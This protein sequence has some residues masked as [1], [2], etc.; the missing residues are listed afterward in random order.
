MYRLLASELQRHDAVKPNV[1]TELTSP[2]SWNENA[3]PDPEERIQELEVQL[4]EL[5][6]KN[7]AEAEKVT[8][9]IDRTRQLRQETEQAQQRAT[10]LQ[11]QAATK[12]RELEEAHRQQRQKQELLDRIAQL[13]SRVCLRRQAL[14]RL[15]D[16]QRQLKELHERLKAEDEA[17]LA[18]IVEEERLRVTASTDS[19]EG[20][21]GNNVGS[22]GDQ[23]MDV[24]SAVEDQGDSTQAVISPDKAIYLG[25]GVA[26]ENSAPIV[27]ISDSVG[28][29][30]EPSI[31]ENHSN[32]FANDEGRCNFLGFSCCPA[33]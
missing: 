27:A 29:E 23:M 8:E 7:R 26:K 1:S 33:A 19:A 2:D 12:E 6:S 17:R 11:V 16:E 22:D 10:E 28:D 31:A 20:G 15:E 25:P 32:K 4:E 3:R 24:D 13:R 30:H 5:K 14:E 21:L 9:I 18:R